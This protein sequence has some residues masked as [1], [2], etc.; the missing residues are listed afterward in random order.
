LAGCTTED[1]SNDSKVMALM[2]C[3]TFC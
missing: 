1:V 2:S 3:S